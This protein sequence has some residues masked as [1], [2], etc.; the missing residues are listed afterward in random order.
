MN[1]L[2]N[3]IMEYIEYC[4]YR[5]RLDSK[6]LKAYRIDLRQYECFCSDL[7]SFFS[8]NI[9][10]N[11]ITSLHREYK[12]KTV[13]RKI[14]SLKA[15]FHYLEYRELLDENPF[16][17][18]LKCNGSLINANQSAMMTYTPK[19]YLVEMS[20]QALTKNIVSVWD[21]CDINVFPDTKEQNQY[22]EK[23]FE[24]LKVKF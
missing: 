17:F 6:T 5:K 2:N 8:K 7:S 11:F 16:G 10:D 22:I 4:E 13:K 24:S 3:Y 9:V 1:T 15:F 12:P 20:K 14:A 21:Y 19:V 23:W 18:G